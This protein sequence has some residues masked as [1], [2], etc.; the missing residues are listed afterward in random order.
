MVNAV[1]NLLNS[2]TALTGSSVAEA[3]TPK[4]PSFGNMLSSAIESV[5]NNQRAAE[6]TTMKVAAG[7]QI[8]MNEIVSIVGKAELTLET[9]LAVRDKAVEAYQEIQR[10]PI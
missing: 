5:A 1:T 2:A 4:A 8:P 3:K 10:M 6:A 9:M 7:E